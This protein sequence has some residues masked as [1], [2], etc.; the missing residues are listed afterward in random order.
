[1]RFARCAAV[2]EGGWDGGYH[3]DDKVAFGTFFLGGNDVRGNVFFLIEF[4]LEVDRTD[5]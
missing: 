2:T 4:G 3:Y 5:T 1:M